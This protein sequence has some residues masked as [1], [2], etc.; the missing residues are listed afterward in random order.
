[1]MTIKGHPKSV[2]NHDARFDTIPECETDISAIAIA[3]L[4]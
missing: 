3:A 4:A 2:S 1:M